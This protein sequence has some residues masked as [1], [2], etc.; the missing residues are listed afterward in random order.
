MPSDRCLD[1]VLS[2]AAAAIRCHEEYPDNQNV[3]AASGVLAAVGILQR[4]WREGR[5]PSGAAVLALL[6]ALEGTP[7]IHH[8]RCNAA[9][10]HRSTS[11]E[12]ASSERRCVLELVGNW[13]CRPQAPIAA[14]AASPGLRWDG[15]TAQARRWQQQEVEATCERLWD[16][17]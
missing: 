3:G 4:M 8:P 12:V 13:V 7:I 6:R 2:A 5:K 14:G 17:L 9:M 16:P 1:A 11:V 10:C 15:G